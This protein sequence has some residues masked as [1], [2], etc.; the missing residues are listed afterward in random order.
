MSALNSPA[1]LNVTVCGLPP[2]VSVT[3]RIAL[4]AP[5]R[6]GVNVTVTVQSAP[7]PSE[8]GQLLL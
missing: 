3:Y 1:L 8:D 5:V 4:R 6:V 2:P 7:A